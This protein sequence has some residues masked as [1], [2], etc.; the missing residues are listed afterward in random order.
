MIEL[1][2]LISLGGGG[3]GGGSSSSNSNKNNMSFD[4]DMMRSHS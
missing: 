4:G 1:N 3:G 2:N